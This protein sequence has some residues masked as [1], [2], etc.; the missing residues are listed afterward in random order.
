[1]ILDQK[2]VAEIKKV[3]AGNLLSLYSAFIWQNTLQGHTHWSDI[4]EGNKP[5]DGDSRAYLEG[6]VASY[7]SRVKTIEEESKTLQYSFRRFSLDGSGKLT[8][9]PTA[10]IGT[11]T[12]L[13]DVATISDRNCP[14]YTFQVK[15]SWR[16]EVMFYGY[17]HSGDRTPICLVQNDAEGKHTIFGQLDPVHKAFG[18]KSLEAVVQFNLR[19]NR[20]DFH[21]GDVWNHVAEE[22][23]EYLV[24][25]ISGVDHS[26][27]CKAAHMFWPTFGPDGVE[28]YMNVR[29]LERGR[30]TKLKV[31]RFFRTILPKATDAQIEQLTDHYNER[32]QK[33]EFILKRSKEQKDFAHAYTHT[34]AK[35]LNPRTSSARKSLPNSCMHEMDVQGK[36]PAEVYA[37][38]DFEILWLETPQKGLLG[39]R[40]VVYVPD[41]RPPQAGP[42]YGTCEHSLD[43]LEDALREM[44]AVMFDNGSN[45]DGARMKA[46]SVYSDSLLMCYCDMADEAELDGDYIVIGEGPL[47]LHTTQGYVGSHGRTRCECCSDPLYEE[48]EYV[49]RHGETFC[50]SCYNDRHT[51]CT[52]TGEE[53]D[54]DEAVEVFTVQS[55]HVW[56]A[57]VDS[58]G[59]I[60]VADWSDAYSTCHYTDEVWLLEDMEVDVDDEY[61]SPRYAQ[62]NLYYVND[63]YHS[64]EQLASRGLDREGNEI[65][66]DEEEAA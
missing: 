8:S 54:T 44:G 49:N 15:D 28:M 2:N 36:S 50:E 48:D 38:G 32:Y 17:F 23:I 37:S 41:D 56:R 57:S 39:G 60:T 11:P 58:P 46:I 65:N 51:F 12:K 18:L 62:N 64:A 3:L 9:Q 7:E 33:R 1:M 14:R 13:L 26:V 4:F 35:M 30:R 27:A 42:V 43:L 40:V 34:I 24:Y 63:A 19:R 59:V 25:T 66:K 16:E 21:N 55:R 61:V 5:L 29:D 52:I 47:E 20:G 53:I 31:G 45:W 10:D 6:L 22:F